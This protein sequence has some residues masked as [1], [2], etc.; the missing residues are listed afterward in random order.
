M[1]KW[2]AWIGR[3]HQQ[4]DILTPALLTRLRATLD[5]DGIGDL[6]PQGVHWCLCAPETA[7]AELGHD[8]HPL[9]SD[10]PASFLPPIPLPRRMWASSALEFH[11]PISAG[12][13]VE[14]IST[15]ASITEKTGGSGTLVFA[16]IDHD[17]L[18]NGTLAVS[19]RQ[20]LVYRG[21]PTTPHEPVGKGRPNLTEWQ[22]HREIT[23]SEALLFRYSALTFNSHRIHYDAPYAVNEE[24]YRALVVPGP[25]T[26]TLLLDLAARKLGSNKL[27]RFSFR[28]QAPAFVNEALH[29]TGRQDGDQ[30]EMAALGSDGRLVMSA[31][32]V[33]A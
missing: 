20:T 6:A 1:S 29:L 18:A 17:T 15:I 33:L 32:A 14:R 2:D 9:R 22:W 12:Q 21:A 10:T 28:G 31:A 30:I 11:T 7:T 23:P 27:K 26:A 4:S 19:E 13:T 5:S 8:G 3:T 24:N 25:L 16:E